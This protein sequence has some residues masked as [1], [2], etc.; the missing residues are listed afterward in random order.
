MLPHDSLGSLAAALFSAGLATCFAWFLTPAVRT[1]A[2]RLNAAQEPRARDVHLEPVPRLGGLAIYLA[3]AG[4][5]LIAVLLTHFVFGKPIWEKSLKP[6]IGVVLAGTLLSLLGFVDDVRELSPGKQLVLQIA[7]V[8]VAL[9]F[10]VRIEVLSNP[11]AHGHPVSFGLWLSYALTL[12]WLVVITNAVNWVDGI[13]GL[14][15]GVSAIAAATLCL[16]AV[17]KG[18][19]ALAILAAALFGSL[20]GFLRYNFNPAKIFM[21]GGSLF[22]GFTLAAIA[23]VGAFKAAT[24]MAIGAPLLVLGLPLFD[25]TMVIFRRWTRGHPIYQADQSHLH[26]R[27][28]ARGFS[29][30]QTVLILYGVS[31]TLCLMAFGVFLV[32]SGQR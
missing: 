19:P 12:L 2:L 1:L 17:L 24:T 30:R 10:G 31:L 11:F 23:T 26:H 22:V 18:Q 29:Q 25:S 4:A 21:G 5:L 8:S 15:A 6:G 13:D 16:M 20:L 9:L 3:F 32:T 14:A 28:L 27:L 7:C